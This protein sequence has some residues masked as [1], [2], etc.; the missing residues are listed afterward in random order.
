M[1]GN[2]GVQDNPDAQGVRTYRVVWVV[3]GHDR[4]IRVDF[5]VGR[6][7]YDVSIRICETWINRVFYL[8]HPE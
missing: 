7:Y 5:L 4:K 1:T 8:G 3:R 2:W 6:W